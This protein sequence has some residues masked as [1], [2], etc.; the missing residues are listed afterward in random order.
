MSYDIGCHLD[1]DELERCALKRISAAEQ[2]RFEEHLLVCDGC[3]EACES[4][5][6]P[7]RALRSAAAVWQ[8]PE[9]RWSWLKPRRLVPAMA[10]LAVCFVGAIAISNFTGKSQAPVAIQLT[11]VRGVSAGAAAPA[12][13]ALSLTP[14]LNGLAPDTSYRLELVNED[15]K[16][17]WQG[18]ISR[19][20]TAVDVPAH[21]AGAFFMRIYSS[22]GELLR[23]YG[24]TVSE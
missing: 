24:L 7:A 17:V 23:E 15:G 14:D 16:I 6:E 11:A 3:R 13:R 21:R 5:G 10:A 19:P 9:P 4:A 2:E 22:S 18:V 12:G 1:P 20:Q 8:E